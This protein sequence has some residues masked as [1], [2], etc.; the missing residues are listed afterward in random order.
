MSKYADVVVEEDRLNLDLARA[1][2]QAT[3][4][5]STDIEDILPQEGGEEEDFSVFYVFAKLFPE[6]VGGNGAGLRNKRMRLHFNKLGYQIYGKEQSRRVPSLRAKPGNPGYGFKRARWRDT[7]Q[8]PEDGLHCERTLRA[9]GCDAAKIERV[10]TAVQQVRWQWHKAR[11]PSRPAGP[12][13]PRGKAAV[14]TEDGET[15]EQEA[16]E[17]VQQVHAAPAGPVPTNANSPCSGHLS[18]SSSPPSQASSSLLE[19]LNSGGKH[20]FLAGLSEQ[21]PSMLGSRSELEQLS[22]L[23]RKRSSDHLDDVSAEKRPHLMLPCP[24]LPF[25]SALFHGFAPPAQL[26]ISP[27]LCILPPPFAQLESRSSDLVLPQLRLP[28]L[29]ES[30]PPPSVPAKPLE[31]LAAISCG[32]AGP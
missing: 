20:A 18:R 27:P 7:V 10:K 17:G 21:L 6:V 31:M 1:F 32:V 9:A 19:S 14:K 28:N 30:P 3:T 8:C 4:K 24:K 22:I 25:S 16:V 15:Q 29:V 12:G 13:R 26:S 23:S 5:V 2:F 11:R